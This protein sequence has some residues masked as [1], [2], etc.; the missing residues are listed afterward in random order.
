MNKY[1]CS[2]NK[3][4]VSAIRVQLCPFAVSHSSVLSNTNYK[5]HAWGL[6]SSQHN[7]TPCLC[8]PSPHPWDIAVR[9]FPMH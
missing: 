2:Y 6:Y 7:S 3:K 5:Q 4:I 8:I 1:I 9:D